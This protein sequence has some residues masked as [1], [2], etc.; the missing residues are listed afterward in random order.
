MYRRTIT[1]AC[2]LIAAV[3][4]A[5]CASSPLGAG[6]VTLIDGDK[7]LGDQIAALALVGDDQSALGTP[8]GV[9]DSVEVF[10]ALVAID[11]RDGASA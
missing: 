6:A 4:L 10:Q 9:A 1:F 7:G 5:G 8:V 11:Q 2:A 3:A